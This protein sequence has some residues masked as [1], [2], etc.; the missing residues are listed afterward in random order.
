MKIEKLTIQQVEKIV[1]LFD[2]YRQ[3]Y[4]QASD[5]DAAKKF[6]MARLEQKQSVIFVAQQDNNYVGFT[7]LY[8]TFSSVGLKPAYILN[9]LYVAKEA[10]KQGVAKQLMSAAIQYAKEKNARYITLETAKDNIIAQSLY[11]KIMTED[12]KIKHY[13]YSFS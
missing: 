7:Q 4:D 9:D 8:P 6:L 1:P 2:A 10:R 5:L 11:E 12:T 3:F 13:T